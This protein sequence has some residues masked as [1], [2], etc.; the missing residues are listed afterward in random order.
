VCPREART[1]ELRSE[2]SAAARQQ[3]QVEESEG[4]GDR[5]GVPLDATQ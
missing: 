2:I 5:S 4:S 1:G 3:K